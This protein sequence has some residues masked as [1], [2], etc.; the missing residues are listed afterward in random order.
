MEKETVDHILNVLRRGTVTWYMRSQ[1][2]NRHRRKKAIGFYK[3]KKRSTE[4]KYKWE[5]KCE[6]CEEYFDSPDVLEVDHIIEIGPFMGNWHEYIMR[7]YCHE[8][9]LQALCTICHKRKTAVF[10]SSL[11]FQRKRVAAVEEDLL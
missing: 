1:V 5:Y 10:N 2:L 4:I 11:R 7:M 3:D 9:N 6:G 8:D